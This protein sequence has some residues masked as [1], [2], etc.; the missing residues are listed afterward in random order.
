MRA[1]ELPW[2]FLQRNGLCSVSSVFY[3]LSS[4][5]LFGLLI[6]LYGAGNMP[7]AL[8]WHRSNSGLSGYVAH[9]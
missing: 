7:P 9:G 3:D 1:G 2:E 6:L 8:T 5:R 4:R